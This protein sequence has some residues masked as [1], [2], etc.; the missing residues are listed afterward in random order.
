MYVAVVT[1]AGRAI[2]IRALRLRDLRDI[3]AGCASWA[4]VSCGDRVIG[5]FDHRGNWHDL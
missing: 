3:V 1:V 4:L 2:E 5:E